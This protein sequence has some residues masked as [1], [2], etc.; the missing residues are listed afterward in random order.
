MSFFQ[1]NI[2]FIFLLFLRSYSMA[3][4]NIK[5]GFILFQCAM[6]MPG[7]ITQKPS[8]LM[9]ISHSITIKSM[10]YVM[11]IGVKPK[12]IKVDIFDKAFK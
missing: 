9:K 8:T 11:Q 6:L 12:M 1:C 10:F 7:T 4:F 5:V 3:F 2:Q